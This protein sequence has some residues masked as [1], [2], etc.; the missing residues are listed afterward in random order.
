VTL[1]IIRNVQTFLS[2]LHF[3]LYEMHNYK[4][5]HASHVARNGLWYTPQ[6][7]PALN[8]S[9]GADHLV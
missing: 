4:I 6:A 8:D 7:T 1:D 3:L 9:V 5:I 2:N